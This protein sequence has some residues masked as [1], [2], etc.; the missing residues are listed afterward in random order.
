MRLG[1]SRPAPKCHVTENNCNS[2]KGEL[3]WPV[4]D[5]SSNPKRTKR[6]DISFFKYEH[7]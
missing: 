1:V 4:P 2:K 5:F 6:K 7:S 3:I